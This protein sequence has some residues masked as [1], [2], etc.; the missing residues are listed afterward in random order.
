MEEVADL[1]EGGPDSAGGRI[2]LT[3]GEVWPE[4]ALEEEWTRKPDD[5]DGDDADRW[6]AIWARGSGAAYRDMVDF[7]ETCTD[8]RLAGMVE[9]ALDGRGAFGGSRM[10]CSTGSKTVKSG[11]SSSTTD[12][13][14][15]R[16]PGSQVPGYRATFRPLEWSASDA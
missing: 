8:A 6:L 1:L 16:V 5:L 3:T 13:A 2:E 14:A 10:C 11:S 9:V 4:F 15:A 12:A 7:A